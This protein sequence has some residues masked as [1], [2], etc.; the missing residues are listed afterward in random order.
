MFNSVDEMILRA[1]QNSHLF[2]WPPLLSQT[3]TIYRYLTLSHAKYTHTLTMF[4]F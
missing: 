4:N 3:Y 1:L 2:P